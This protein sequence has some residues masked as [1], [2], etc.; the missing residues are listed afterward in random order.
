VKSGEYYDAGHGSRFRFEL[1]G[2]EGLAEAS[3]R[4]ELWDTDGVNELLASGSG[5][6]FAYA[7]SDEATRADLGDAYVSFYL[8]DDGSGDW[9]LGEDYIKS[10]Q[11]EVVGWERHI[12]T[13]EVSGQIPGVQ[14]DTIRGR[15]AWAKALSDRELPV[16]QKRESEDD[17]RSP[18]TLWIMPFHNGHFDV[19]P[20]RPDQS[21][22][23]NVNR[24]LDSGAD[25]I[26]TFFNVWCGLPPVSAVGCTESGDSAAV[27]YDAP[28]YTFIHEL[29]HLFGA[30]HTWDT[31]PWKDYLMRPGGEGNEDGTRQILR[32][33]DARD[34]YNGK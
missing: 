25:V 2:G 30:G 11:F 29:G 31:E 27:T 32:K 13:F 26:F 4:Y 16:V 8:D 28:K 22:S 3:V 17:W 1:T 20:A 18:I 6:A 10:P 33:A 24:H 19:S 34:F 14:M 5:T 7:F 15:K 21:A 23:Y 9:N 12:I